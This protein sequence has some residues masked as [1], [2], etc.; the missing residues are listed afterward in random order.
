[1]NVAAARLGSR[2]G[3]AGAWLSIMARACAPLADSL[4]R[5]GVFHAPPHPGGTSGNPSRRR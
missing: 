1:M 2:E 3:P 5:C 4:A